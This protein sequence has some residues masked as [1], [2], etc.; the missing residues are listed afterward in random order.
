[1][2]FCG[3]RQTAVF[4]F[5]QQFGWSFSN[6]MAHIGNGGVGEGWLKRPFIPHRPILRPA[7]STSLNR[8]P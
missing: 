7:L 4:L 6:L 3:A 2:G 8:Q 1:M 5:R